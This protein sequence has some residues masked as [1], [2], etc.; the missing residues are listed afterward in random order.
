[1]TSTYLVY[2]LVRTLNL[3]CVP[4]AIDMNAELQ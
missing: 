2:A 3:L 4:L 1:M